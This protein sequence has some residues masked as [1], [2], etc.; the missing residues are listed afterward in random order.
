MPSAAKLKKRAVNKQA[1]AIARRAVTEKV[2]PAEIT[3]RVFTSSE[4][5]SLPLHM[6]DGNVLRRARGALTNE[7]SVNRICD[8]ISR[9]VTETDARR[10]VGVCATDWGQWKRHNECH[11]N[12]KLA[13]AID[14]QHVAT[15]DECVRL[16]SQLREE[17]R[18]ALKV[19]NEEM[20]E[21]NRELSQWYAL[22]KSDRGER[23]AEPT[24]CGPT[25]LDMKM[26]NSMV[27]H[28]Q[29]KLESLSK[30]HTPKKETNLNVNQNI[31]QEIMTATTEQ[32]A[33]RAYIQLIDNRPEG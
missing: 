8:L 2:D 23:P 19:Y 27:Q 18:S 24:Y 9:G 33:M 11:V 12:E 28:L 13:F 31:Y 7:A 5:E 22:P 26:D 10:Y 30:Q 17:R 21:Y 15:A 3:G 1:H 4:E 6:Q 32:D 14:L 20:R 29:W 16:L 25:E